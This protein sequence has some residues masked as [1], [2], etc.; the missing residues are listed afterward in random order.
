MIFFFIL[1]NLREVIL[2]LGSIRQQAITCANVYI[3]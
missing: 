1:M 3:W 2:K